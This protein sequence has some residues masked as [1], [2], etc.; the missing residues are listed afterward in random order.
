MI[1]ILSSSQD[2][3]ALAI[4]KEID[5]LGGEATLLDLAEY[6]QKW[7]L[8]WIF[9]NGVRNFYLET[10]T[11]SEKIDLSKQ[12]VIWWR[13]PQAFNLHQQM[14]NQEYRQFAYAEMY[15]AFTGMWQSLDAFWINPPRRDDIA[16]RKVFQLGIAQEVDLNIPETLISSDPQKA[17]AFFEEHGDQNIIYKAFTATSQLWRETRLLKSDELSLIDNVKFAPVIFQKYV[18]AVYDLRITVVGS[19]IFAAAIYSQETS[20]KVDMRMDIS[21]ARIEPVTLPNCV[22][23]KL[24]NLM[25]RLRLVYG[26]IDMRL[27]PD[28]EYVFLEINP[29]GQW[30]F[31]EE[32]TNQPITKSLASLMVNSV[33]DER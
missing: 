30:L 24:S 19:S 32:K 33:C 8:N 12:Q 27:T 3:H 7:H 25:N 20:Y 6:P 14:T 5:A 2:S 26:A 1:L 21:N 4:L 22:C 11:G 17:R 9:E 15:E 16:H 23:D 28:G 10:G 13:R 29:A 18:P 31:I